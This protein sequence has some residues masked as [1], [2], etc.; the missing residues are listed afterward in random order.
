MNCR[1]VQAIYGCTDLHGEF[2]S[3]TTYIKDGNFLASFLGWID[4][5]AEFTSDKQAVIV[6]YRT[7]GFWSRYQ[8]AFGWNQAIK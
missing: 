2:I 8:I 5:F 3:D 6:L 4:T 1:N 7:G